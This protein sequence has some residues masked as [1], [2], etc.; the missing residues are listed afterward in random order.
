MGVFHHL[1]LAF[2]AEFISPIKQFRS[3]GRVAWVFYYVAGIWTVHRL[4]LYYR[5]AKAHDHGR[6]GYHFTLVCAVAAFAWML[7]AVVNIKDTKKGILN[8]TAASYFGTATAQHWNNAGVRIQAHQA[9]LPLPMMLIGSEKIGIEKGWNSSKHAMIAGF[10]TGLPMIGGAMSRTSL[11]VSIRTA[12]LRAD[13]LFPRTILED[14]NRE[15]N[16]L[17]LRS[18]EPLNMEEERLIGLG[19]PVYACAEYQLYSVA[20]DTVKKAYDRIIEQARSLDATGKPCYLV[21]SR[22]AST[23]ETLWGASCYRVVPGSKLLDTVFTTSGQV[24][25]SY[26]VKLEPRE[27]LT[28]NRVYSIDRAWKLAGGV[29]STANV[30]SGWL[31]VSDDLQTEAGKHHVFQIE[32][33]PGTISRVMLRRADERI[34]HRETSGKTYLNNVPIP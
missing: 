10:S 8:P 7:D 17:L 27:E 1:G 32:A 25:L 11:E 2:L 23:D 34:I 3:L 6:Y 18:D 26:W 20:V 29:G 4:Y 9:I 16:I 33:R 19:R 22:A 31:F 14:L 13:S 15:R 5:Y 12:Q 30:R 21:P 24:N 28:P